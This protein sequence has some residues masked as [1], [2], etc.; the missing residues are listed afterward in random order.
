MINKHLTLLTLSGGTVLGVVRT[1]AK[2]YE[3][4]LCKVYVTV[5]GRGRPW[6]TR[7][8]WA[9]KWQRKLQVAICQRYH[10]CNKT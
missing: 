7:L 3:L 10:I 6:K 2:Y 8:F 9:L 4:C 1:G 5:H